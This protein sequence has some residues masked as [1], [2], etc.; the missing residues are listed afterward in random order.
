MRPEELYLRDILRSTNAI[1]EF[2]TEVSL[3][4]FLANDLICSA[5]LLKLIIIGEAAS[6]L[7]QPFKERHAEIEWRRIVAFR[8]FAVHAYFGLDW[9]VVWRA[10]TKNAPEIKQRISAIL[11]AEFPE[12][13]S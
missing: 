11:D 1:A 4:Q 7:P 13:Q 12:A 3:D 2:L 6:K 9:K 10:A 5:V 8:N